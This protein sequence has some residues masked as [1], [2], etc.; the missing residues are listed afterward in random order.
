[1]QPDASYCY[2]SQPKAQ[3]TRKDPGEVDKTSRGTA[4]A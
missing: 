4:N 1:M 2:L 3:W